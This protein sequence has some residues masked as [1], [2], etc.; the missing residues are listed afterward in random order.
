M[1][2][3]IITALLA[4]LCLPVSVQAI[5]LKGHL[6]QGGMVIGKVDPATKVRFHGKRVLVSPQ[7][8]F[9]IGFSRDAKAD[10]IIELRRSSGPIQRFPLHIKRRSYR[11][12]RIN[13]LPPD[14]VTP[15]PAEMVRIRKESALVRKARRR[16]DPRIAFTEPFIWPVTGR[17]SGV[18]GSQRIL[19]GKPRRPHLGVDIAVPVGTPVKAAADG[20]VSLADDDMFFS[21]GTLIIDHGHGISTDYLHLHKIL[22]KPGQRV[23]RGDVVALSGASG[24][25]TGPHLHW[26]MNWFQTRLDPSLMVPPM[27]KHAPAK[28]E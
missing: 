23:H 8:L 21:G 19:N 20:V 25:V 1:R 16:D 2:P 3:I 22:V 10:A 24:R 9:V 26:G 28:K 7:G 27:P 6:V 15:S 13:G 4:V 17:I 11:I 18:Y 12:Q 5:T 14:K